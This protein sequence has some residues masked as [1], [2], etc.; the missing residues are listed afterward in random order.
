[1]DALAK[2][3]QY[4][5]IYTDFFGHLLVNGSNNDSLFKGEILFCVTDTQNTNQ[6]HTCLYAY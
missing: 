4:M 6:G 1:M 3:K 2:S 5:C